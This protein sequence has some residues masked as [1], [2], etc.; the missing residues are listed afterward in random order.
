MMDFSFELAQPADDPY[1]RH[2]LASSIMPG[3]LAVTFEREPNYFLGCGT[4]GRF[5]Q[6]IIARHIPSSEIAAVLCRGIRPYFVNGYPQDVGYI[7]QIRV[8]QKYRGQQLLRHGLEYFR[9]LHADGRSPAYWGVI[10]EEN[11]IA[12][13]VLVEQPYTGFPT[14]RQ[15]ARIYTLGIILSRPFPVH[16][17]NIQIEGGSIASLPE[18]IAF[19]RQHGAQRQLFPAYDKSD[20]NGG[21][22]TLGFD[23]NDFLIAR[24]NDQ[25]VGMLGLWDQAN[26][27]QTTVRGY[28]HS[29]ALLRP[30]YNLG[31]HLLGAQPMPGAGKHIL[32]A[33]ASFICIA[34]NDPAVFAALL[35]GVYNLAAE[36]HYA[37]LM[38][39]LAETDPLLPIARQY[40]HISYHSRLYMAG[41]AEASDFLAGLDSRPPYIEIAML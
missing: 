35:R 17:T 32:S 11:T 23:I 24:R 12:R 5:W 31:A 6:I 14:A 1:L 7:G 33:Y 40:L 21:A 4:M 19:L 36:R 16:S 30:L 3:R 25:I 26:Y 10:S 15:L 2:L 27:K 34:G 20:F 8:A 41:W 28:A 13:K 37:H 29:L 9:T 22:A 18:I 38:L 39:G